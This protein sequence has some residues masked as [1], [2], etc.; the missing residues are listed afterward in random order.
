MEERIENEN[1][2]VDNAITTQQTSLVSLFSFLPPS[3]ETRQVLCHNVRWESK[4][5]QAH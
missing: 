4:A 2:Y 3:N 1:G 5:I